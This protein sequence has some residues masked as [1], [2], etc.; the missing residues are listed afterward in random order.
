MSFTA[1]H[2]R[3]TAAMKR[4]HRGGNGPYAART[5]VTTAAVRRDIPDILSRPYARARARD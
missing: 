5:Y 2:R 4:A 3:D 1:A